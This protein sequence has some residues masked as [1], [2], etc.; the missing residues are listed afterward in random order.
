MRAIFLDIETTGLDPGQHSP[1]DI[2]FKIVDM[3]SLR[4]LTTYSSI[5]KHPP[6]V[7]EKRDP[8]SIE[9]N[10][11]T[12]DAVN[13]GTPLPT[14]REQILQIFSERQIQRG[15]AVFICQ[16]PSFDRSFF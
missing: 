2:A 7:W 5:I 12:W 4:T 11:F 13:N 15:Y 10:G 3:T 8:S 9:I 14:V 1:I 6:D 16:N